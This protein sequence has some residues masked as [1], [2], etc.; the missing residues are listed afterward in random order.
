MDRL[1]PVTVVRCRSDVPVQRVTIEM[2]GSF[3]HQK[4]GEVV[5]ANAMS[6]VGNCRSL[7]AEVDMIFE[8]LES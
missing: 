6:C 4:T 8:C 2:F 1:S 5:D 3:G 7:A